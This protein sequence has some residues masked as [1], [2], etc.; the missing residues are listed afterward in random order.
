[1]PHRK[2]GYMSKK[3]SMLFELM[4]T[5]NFLDVFEHCLEAP[6]SLQSGQ[7]PDA[8]IGHI[9]A[10]WNGDGWHGNYFPCR[11]ELWTKA[12]NRESQD[13]YRC[14]V[15]QF[16][17]LEILREFCKGHP[18]SHVGENEY[19]FFMNGHAADYWIRFIT[20]ENDYNLYLKGYKKN[21]QHT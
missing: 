10:Y 2:R 4:E 7:H 15:T 13:I 6:D 12:F 8:Q 20:R 11:G 21:C 3:E 14:L 5:C 19:N 17:N 16:Y 9:R 18:S 1:M